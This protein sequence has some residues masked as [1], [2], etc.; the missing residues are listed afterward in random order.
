MKRQIIYLILGIFLI[1][2]VSAS[3]TISPSTINI[4]TYPGETHSVNITIMADGN[5]L[6]IFNSSNQDISI[7]PS[8]IE[9]INGVMNTTINLTFSTTISVGVHTFDVRGGTEVLVVEVPS[10]S[11]GK[12]SSSGSGY[13]KVDESEPC[14]TC[15][16]LYP[17]NNTKPIECTDGKEKNAPPIEIILISIGILLMALL[18]YIYLKIKR[19]NGTNTKES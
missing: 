8:S 1:G 18:L 3:V 12:C 10:S 4:D 19:K 9:T 7:S 2:I 15:S 6:L 14:K 17:F 13:R 5:Y 16:T 11:S